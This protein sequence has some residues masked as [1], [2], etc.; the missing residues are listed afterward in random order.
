[1][2]E[3]IWEWPDEGSE[4]E[5]PHLFPNI[6]YLEWNTK[7]GR[8]FPQYR[9]FVGPRLTTLNLGV[10]QS[11]VH[12]SLLP[13]LA[14]QCPRLQE[15]TI[16]CSEF[17]LTPQ[18]HAFSFITRLW[19]ELRHLEVACL[20]GSSLDHL[21]S[22][23][24]LECLILSSQT[25]WTFAIIPAR[26][27]AEECHD[28]MDNMSINVTDTHA[29]S[30]VL[31]RFQTRPLHALEIRLPRDTPAAAFLECCS[32]VV[33]QRRDHP[34]SSLTIQCKAFTANGNTVAD[35]AQITT[36]QV[37]VTLLSPLF[38][39][40]NLTCVE[41]TAPV[42]FDFDNDSIASLACAWPRI[43]HLELVSS[44]F[45]NIPSR[46]TLLALV[47]FAKHCRSL[48]LLKL[49][50]NA[51]VVPTWQTLASSPDA[52]RPQQ[53][54][55]SSLYVRDSPVGSPLAVAVFL[56][57]L[58]P[59]LRHISTSSQGILQTEQVEQVDPLNS[60]WKAVEKALPLL[61]VARAEER[62]WNS[63]S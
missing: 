21:S 15:V 56:S 55:L 58:F 6:E 50:L 34:P 62:Y 30:E 37:A 41:L 49:S 32:A 40:E 46:A 16:E 57:S 59:K 14:T 60:Q 13:G 52:P 31:S 61:G 20:D 7:E 35:A 18:R 33:G 10:C 53:R 3:D 45:Q 44:M 54:V 63:S 12:L 9:L 24:S 29:V 5:I 42:G 4:A 25:P 17:D 28:P 1:M 39:F 19:K 43:Q 48:R 36:Y 2:P 38:I 8:L 26:T 51:K 23:P 27:E 47:A 22:L 11:V